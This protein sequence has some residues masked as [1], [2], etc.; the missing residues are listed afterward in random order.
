M[1]SMLAFL[2]ALLVMP[3]VLAE[4]SPEKMLKVVIRNATPDIDPESFAARPKT[5]FRFGAH[6]AR[7]EEEPNPVTG[8]HGLIVVNRR[9]TWMT[10]LASKSGQHIVDSAESYDF[11]APIAGGPGEPESVL[12]MEFGCEIRYM[13]DRG[14]EPKPIS[15]AGLDLSGF[16]TN[17]DKYVFRLL[18]IPEH[19]V[20]F[21]FALYEDNKLIYYLRYDEYGSGLEP[22]HAL[23]TKPEGIEYREAE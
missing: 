9:D 23:F 8:I 6:Y 13:R 1:K 16:T 19:D 3:V 10:D 4:C 22:D 12:E 11:H 21:A 5:L 18:T 20:P 2:V 17:V 14:V 15:I 7:I